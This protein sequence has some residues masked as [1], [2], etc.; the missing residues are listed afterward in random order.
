[1]HL[2]AVLVLGNEAKGLRP[3]T[4]KRCSHMLAIP[5]ARDFNSLN[6]AQAAAMLMALT[7]AAHA[8]GG[9]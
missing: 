9:E 6:V 5:L 8:R 4:I 3:G 1:M 7:A 2:P